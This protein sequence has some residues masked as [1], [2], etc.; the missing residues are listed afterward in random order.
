M[1]FR[2]YSPGYQ[3]IKKLRHWL[4]FT[5]KLFQ[6]ISFLTNTRTV[7]PSHYRNM[8]LKIEDSDSPIRFWNCDSCSSASSRVRSIRDTPASTEC[9]REWYCPRNGPAGIPPRI[10][11]CVCSWR[12]PGKPQRGIRIWCTSCTADDNAYRWPCRLTVSERPARWSP[13]TRRSSRPDSSRQLVDI[14]PAK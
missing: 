2:K 6:K 12:T 14:V 3:K 13:A 5:R 7:T 4:G 9:I 11:G 8:H 10:I 1:K